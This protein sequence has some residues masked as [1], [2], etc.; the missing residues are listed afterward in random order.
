MSQDLLTI[1]QAATIRKDGSVELVT[2]NASLAPG[3]YSFANYDEFTAYLKELGG[4]NSG[5]GVRGTMARK[6]LYTRSGVTFG[7]PVLD[8]ISSSTGSL[9]IGDKTIDLREFLDRVMDDTAAGGVIL[10]SPALKF[11]GMVNGAE[12]WASDDGSTVEYRLGKGRLT[13]HAWK[14]SSITQYWSMGAEV[15]VSNTPANF[16][17]ADITSHY[18]MSV[19]APC[20]VVKVDSDSDRHDSYVDEYEWGWNSQQPERV[21]SLCR[22]VWHGMKFADLVT[23]GSGC[24]IFRNDNWPIGFPADW[25]TISTVPNL[26]GNWTD[27]S[28]RSAVISIDFKA[29][30]VNMSAFGRPTAHGT[31]QD[32]S[33]ISVTFPDDKTYTGQLIAPNRI[34][35]SNGSTWTKIIN[36]VMDLN[37]NW[38]DGS[39]RSA[40]I[41]EGPSAIKVDMSDYDRP[42]AQGSIVNA[43]TISIT[44]PDDKTYTAQLQPPNQIRWSN[45]SVWTRKP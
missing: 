36:T 23:A 28:S 32:G 11:T 25:N 2:H 1:K 39:A 43:S 33:S 10:A 13:F 19:D 42:N 24:E 30:T 35:W 44:F 6:G 26:N 38:T 16:Q 45:G 15:T 27:G 29:I 20:Q 17:V 5:R 41:T 40:A 31:V 4:R 18:Y 9:V 12:R 8:A 37:G 22:A 3:R 34:R 21:A 14:K 7:D